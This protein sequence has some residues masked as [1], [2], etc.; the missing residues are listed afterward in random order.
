MIVMKKHSYIKKLQA[1]ILILGLAAPFLLLG[2]STLQPDGFWHDESNTEY[3]KNGLGTAFCD[4]NGTI[5]VFNYEGHGFDKG[6]NTY[7]YTIN[8]E[9]KLG[10]QITSM[11]HFNVGSIVPNRILWGYYGESNAH[12]EGD[13]LGRNFCF[14]FNSRLWYFQ[15]IHA[16]I[17]SGLF[18]KNESYECYAQVPVDTTN[19]CYTYYHTHSP[20]HT[21]LKMGAFQLDSMLYFV[22]KYSDGSMQWMIQEFS[23]DVSIK[24]FHY[25]KNIMLP[26]I[27]TTSL[28]MLG[29]LVKRL[30]ADGNEY[31]ILNLYSTDG[32]TQ[33]IGKL[34]PE[35][36]SD[37]KR[38]FTWTPLFDN[39]QII[40]G[41]SNTATTIVEGTMK[42]YRES[43]PMPES[44]DRLVWFGLNR[45]QCS[46]GYYKISFREFY[47]EN[48]V[49][50][51]G[52]Y[53]EI[54]PPKAIAP[55]KI[56]DNF[57]LM[58]SF[59]L[60]PRD[61][62]TKMNGIDGYQQYIWLMY[63]DNDHHFNGLMLQS[64]LWM[65]DPEDVKFNNDLDNEALYDNIED[66]WTL[67]GIIDGPPPVSVDWE[68]WDE[69][70]P[71]LTP[72]SSLLFKNETSKKIEFTSTTENNWSI[73]E[74]IEVGGETKSKL[75]GSLSE[76]FK[77]S[78]SYQNAYGSGEGY[79]KSLEL[80]FELFETG[81]E[82]G[83]YIFSVPHI[84]RYTYALYPWW[85]TD[86]LD[87]PI[88]NSLQYLFKTTDVT[89]VNKPIPLEGYPF[90]V[91]EPNSQDL[92]GWKP[93]GGRYDM[94][95]HITDYDMQSCVTL[96]WDDLSNGQTEF[97]S[98]SLD[99]TSSS[100]ATNSYEVK[101]EAGVSYSG[102]EVFEISAKVSAGYEYTYTT[103]TK[104]Q[105]EFK[106]EITA[107]LD[108]LYSQVDGL[109]ISHLSMNGYWFWPE[110]NQ[111]WWFY[112]SLGSQQPWYLA[113][114][115]NTA[116][117]KLQLLSPGN[118]S[119][120]EDT[121][122]L[123]SWQVEEGDLK[124]FTF[125]LS[126]SPGIS[127]KNI[128]FKEAVGD[129]TQYSVPGFKPEKGITYYWAVR[130]ISADG[131]TIWSSTHEFT[132]KQ[133]QTELETSSLK[134]V[135][136]PNPAT[137]GNIN[138]MID[139]EEECKMEVS[140]FAI[141]GKLMATEEFQNA[142]ANPVTIR[143]SGCDF[144]PGIY[145][146]VIRAGNEKLVRK[147]MVK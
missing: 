23:F 48:D 25:I 96:G 28:D 123:F 118:K 65:L 31:M 85:E 74:S 140:I 127:V 88:T 66:L 125:Y 14:Q 53:G 45:Y 54:N 93:N 87:Y 49:M 50:I 62:T 115:V 9:H 70:H 146:A 112:D 11:T 117:A 52:T 16:G 80:N 60:Q 68:T 13:V 22:S 138:I 7:M 120:L 27:N 92:L 113:W 38:T 21:Q 55:D 71:P 99:S 73:G 58:A 82:M 4:F 145:F 94:Q 128:L 3:Y 141:D 109:N 35:I 97:L 102:A 17:V 139:P 12:W 39:N 103:E 107:S 33:S 106:N 77:C 98:V 2:Q 75:S 24:E 51:P 133:D 124:D 147:V 26:D 57:Q 8:N 78:K 46:E 143:F 30:D 15:H 69:K 44:P 59:E 130:G 41:V 104:V 61:F 32:Y 91:S 47:F 5:Y 43:D 111:D 126:K 29:G 63:P 105:T 79:S 101:V 108:N 19:D 90:Y 129:V 100:E 67:I 20:A 40:P 42:A 81:Q 135:V 10:D 18:E 36:G 131:A 89:T 136:Y 56:G 122:L 37:G 142:D 64:D 137:K 110:D 114:I 34:T 76:E 72:A 1:I 119:E 116:Y 83:Y 144:M 121:E 134:A 86:A 95:E 84:K 6:G 132:M